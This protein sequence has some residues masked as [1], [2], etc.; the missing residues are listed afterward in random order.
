MHWGT[1]HTSRNSSMETEVTKR[2][3]KAPKGADLV[4]WKMRKRI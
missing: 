2:V 4:F 3:C 1:D